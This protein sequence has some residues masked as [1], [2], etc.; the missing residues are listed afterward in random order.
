MQYLE[1]FP[2][3]IVIYTIILLFL[4][5]LNNPY[6]S[7]LA[8][9]YPL[10]ILLVVLQQLPINN[11]YLLV[12]AIAVSLLYY[13]LILIPTS[14]HLE[15]FTDSNTVQ[16][17]PLGPGVQNKNWTTALENTRYYQEVANGY[18][19]STSSGQAG[20]C[21]LDDRF[22]YQLGFDRVNR[23]QTGG[24]LPA[25]ISSSTS[26]GSG[27]STGSNAFPI[28]SNPTGCLSTNGTDFDLECQKQY[29]KNVGFREI[30]GNGCPNGQ[31]RVDCS[32]GH[33]GGIPI[34]GTG[35]TT[36][37]LRMDLPPSEVLLPNSQTDGDANQWCR[38]ERNTRRA[39]ATRIS[40]GVSAG[41]YQGAIPDNNA[42]RADC[43]SNSQIPDIGTSMT[44]CKS[45][46]TPRDEWAKL[47]T[48]GN[49]IDVVVG[50]CPPTQGRGVCK[51]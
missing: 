10:I 38:L 4:W 46:D 25:P 50:D 5:A 9:F 40:N 44:E 20:P 15:N 35:D 47:C 28:I 33:K 8:L 16:D 43:Q 39:R 7:I 42:T 30:T 24:S 41:C 3:I 22:G 14:N 26:G 37:C 1:Y 19:A 27:P 17:T 34:N 11:T 31:S 13:L 21:V 36:N 32:T 49:L 18:P 2:P 29:G 23:C 12:I 48:S 51:N 45:W 6:L